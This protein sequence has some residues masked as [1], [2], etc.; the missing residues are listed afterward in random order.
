MQIV[1]PCGHAA[2][3]INQDN[4][5][6][7]R[8]SPRSVRGLEGLSRV[9]LSEHFFLRDFLYSEVAAL[10]G[11]DNIPDDPDVA[12][13][14]GEQLCQQ[15]LEPLQQHFGPLALRSG[16]RNAALNAFCNSQ[17]YNCSRNPATAANHIWDMR[18]DRGG[19]GAMVTVVV[20]AFLPEYDATG[21]WRP[22][23]WWLHDHLPYS[24]ICFFPKLAAFNLGW[25]EF[26]LQEIRSFAPPKGLLFKPGMTVPETRPYPRC[27][28]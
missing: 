16:Y 27:L 24:E 13:A 19:I 15:L 18:D 22:L 11:L 12:I 9:R 3:R 28:T 2:D 26:P 8:R 21:D 7:K 5:M 1:S 23:A 25:R 10:H 20:P 4:I 6:G 17:G 14:A